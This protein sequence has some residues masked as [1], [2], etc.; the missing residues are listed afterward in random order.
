MNDPRDEAISNLTKAV[1][2]LGLTV[3]LLSTATVFVS[4]RENIFTQVDGTC[5]VV[6]EPVSACGNAFSNPD[7]NVTFLGMP[8]NTRKGK[9]LFKQNCAACHT[10]NTKRLTGPGLEGVFTRIPSEKWFLAMVKN[11]DSLKEIKDPY[12]M[13]RLEDFNGIQMTPFDF[14]SNEEVA[15]IAA[16]LKEGVGP[17]PQIAVP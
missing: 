14:L 1:I 10:T 4:F 12:L 9:K 8:G 3:L 6:D 13:K 17:I 5:G 15:H 2:A 7:I 11:Q 16:Y